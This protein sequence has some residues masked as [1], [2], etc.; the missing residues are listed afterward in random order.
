MPG[1]PGFWIARSQVD[2]QGPS[3]HSR[4]ALWPLE[5]AVAWQPSSHLEN[6]HLF[7]SNGEPGT[8]LN[9]LKAESYLILTQ[10]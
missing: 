9:T 8:L 4:I 2:L 5:R 6:E 1:K 7:G 3:Q 10:R